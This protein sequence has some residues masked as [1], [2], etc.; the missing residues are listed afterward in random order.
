MPIPGLSPLLSRS[1]IH[2]EVAPDDFVNTSCGEIHVRRRGNGPAMVLL[3]GFGAS[4]YSWRDLEPL[5]STSFTTVAI[6]LTGFGWTERPNRTECYRLE[7]QVD[8]LIEI[9]DHFD[10]ESA[11]LCGHSYGTAVAA[12][13]A[14][15]HPERVSRLVLFSPISRFGQPPWFLRNFVAVHLVYVLTRFFLSRPERFRKIL[16][17][18]F[19]RDG[20]L[21]T[22]VAEEY[23]RR[24]LVEGFRDAFFGFARAMGQD[25]P[26]RMEHS[27]I[28]QPALLIAGAEDPIVPED[29][30]RELVTEMRDA[31]LEV[32]P[33]CGHS[34]P[35]E[36]PELVATRI[37]R[38]TG[39]ERVG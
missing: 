12:R 30:C 9:L 8:T 36:W 37:L 24:L 13:T 21:T 28:T 22:V 35:E 1:E 5:L 15:R 4:V 20:V 34:A 29:S 32:L 10:F 26:P 16:G 33:G 31:S 27:K 2:A 18:A 7:K 25:G 23:R 38:F 11:V 19:F 3:H 39:E 14:M 17:R 6:D